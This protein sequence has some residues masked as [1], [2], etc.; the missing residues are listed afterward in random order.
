[1]TISLTE[2][3]ANLEKYM[4]LARI[5]DIHITDESQK[6]TWLLT[7]VKRDRLM[8]TLLSPIFSGKT[9]NTANA[10]S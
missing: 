9:V 10:P 5:A 8:K 2:F 4:K 3:K 1:M 7:S 6:E